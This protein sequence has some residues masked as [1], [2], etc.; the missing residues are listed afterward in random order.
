MLPKQ[1]KKKKV[2]LTAVHMCVMLVGSEEKN[3]KPSW[4]PHFEGH[5]ILDHSSIA[6]ASQIFLRADTKI[7]DWIL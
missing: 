2:Y 4:F 1:K 5:D 3:N 7:W 6:G